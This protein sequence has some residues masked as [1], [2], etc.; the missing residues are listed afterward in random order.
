M[1]IKINFGI[2]PTSLQ[3]YRSKRIRMVLKT[4]R[5]VLKQSLQCYCKLIAITYPNEASTPFESD[6]KLSKG[7]IINT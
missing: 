2:H 7:K 1:I 5:H 3:T 6:T 4:A